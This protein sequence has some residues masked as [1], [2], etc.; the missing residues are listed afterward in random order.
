MHRIGFDTKEYHPE[1]EQIMRDITMSVSVQ[2][3]ETGETHNWLQWPNLLE[4]I[5]HRKK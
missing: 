3:S 5:D 4:Q 1:Y 2:N